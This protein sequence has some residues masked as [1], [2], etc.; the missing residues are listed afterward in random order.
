MTQK[1]NMQGLEQQVIV[2]LYFVAFLAWRPTKINRTTIR[3]FIYAGVIDTI[4]YFYDYKK[5]LFF[6]S[7][8]VWL[9]GVWLL[10]YFWNTE[11]G[12]FIRHAFPKRY[13]YDK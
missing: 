9:V 2:I 12:I 4:M 7:V 1:W 6:G 11:K 5:P 8:Y 13:K 10:V 3:A